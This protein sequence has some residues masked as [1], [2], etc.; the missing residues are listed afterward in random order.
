MVLEAARV[1]SDRLRFHEDELTDIVADLSCFKCGRPLG[2]VARSSAKSQVVCP[3]CHAPNAVV[4][5][6]EA[7]KEANTLR[8][9]PPKR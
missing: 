6:W 5:D 3:R 4:V 7:I 9:G 1:R 8:P 2:S